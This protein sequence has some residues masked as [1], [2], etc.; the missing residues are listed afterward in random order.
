MPVFYIC[1]GILLLTVLGEKAGEEKAHPEAKGMLTSR[2]NVET[3]MYPSQNVC[4]CVFIILTISSQSMPE[5]KGFMKSWA[6]WG[7]WLP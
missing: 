5:W 6:L 4:V 3:R 1:S 7:F 2:V